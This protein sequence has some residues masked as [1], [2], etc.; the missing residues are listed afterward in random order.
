[1]RGKSLRFCVVKTHSRSTL[2]TPVPSREGNY[3]QPLLRCFYATCT[4]TLVRG[5]VTVN[6]EW[7]KVRCAVTLL[8]SFIQ[9]SLCWLCFF[10]LQLTCRIIEWVGTQL[11][12]CEAE[13]PTHSSSKQMLL[14]VIHWKFT[15][16]PGS[17]TTASWVFCRV[18]PNLQT[19]RFG[20]SF[21]LN[22][23]SFQ[24]RIKIPR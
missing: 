13:R 24:H 5:N 2:N 18:I 21:S 4:P 9:V 20:F 7:S 8:H 1:M 12:A 11:L 16:A 23:A 6:V 19:P 14:T 3:G 17:E 22:T 15:T 10:L